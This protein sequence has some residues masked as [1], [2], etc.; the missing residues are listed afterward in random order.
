MQAARIFRGSTVYW[1]IAWDKAGAK[2]TIKERVEISGSDIYK[3]PP[4]W[5]TVPM[6]ITN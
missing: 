3:K 6:V 2:P 1:R 4:G 5:A